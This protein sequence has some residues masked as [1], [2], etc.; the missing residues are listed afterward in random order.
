VLFPPQNKFFNGD[1][2]YEAINGA[3]EAEVSNGYIN[4]AFDAPTNPQVDAFRLEFYTRV[5]KS[6]QEGNNGYTPE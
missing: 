5:D 2:F 4:F 3:K 1:V 6:T